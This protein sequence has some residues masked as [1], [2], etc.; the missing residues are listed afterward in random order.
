MNAT[1]T[2]FEVEID[3]AVAKIWE[4]IYSQQSKIRSSKKQLEFRSVQNNA[5]SLA[6]VNAEIIKAQEIAKQLCEEASEIEAPF[7]KNPWNR[8]FLV[9]GGHIHRSMDCSTC[10]PTTQFGWLPDLSGLTE[11]DAVEAHGARLCSVCFPTAPIEWTVGIAK[12]T[13]CAGTGTRGFGKNG[14]EPIWSDRYRACGV[15]EEYIAVTSYG[16]LRKHKP[17][18]G[19]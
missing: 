1:V 7:Y 9:H 8:F 14:A 6:M 4:K 5:D 19:A 2:R 13:G 11:A 12:P 3:T 15:C 16:V 17:K 18:A 10:Y